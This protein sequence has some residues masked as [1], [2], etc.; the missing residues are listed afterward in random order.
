M[1]YVFLIPAAAFFL[2]F[3]DKQ[4]NSSSL[5]PPS[6]SCN[7]DNGFTFKPDSDKIGS[8]H[9]LVCSCRKLPY[10]DDY[11]CINAS[12]ESCS[13]HK[14]KMALVNPRFDKFGFSYNYHLNLVNSGK[15]CNSIV[16]LVPFPVSETSHFKSVRF[17][18]F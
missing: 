15:K 10:D 14:R 4:F 1:A 13:L 5:N 9:S 17:S 3:F 11:S 6:D 8:N 7:C 18:D 12:K 2:Y 16:G